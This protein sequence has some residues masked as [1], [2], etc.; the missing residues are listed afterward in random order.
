MNLLE[1]FLKY[2]SIHTTSN[3]NTGLVPSTPQQMEFAKILAEELKDMGMQDVS[4][5]KKGYLM[6]TLPSNIDKDVPTVG[7]PFLPCRICLLYRNCTVTTI[8]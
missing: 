4:L 8:D 7:L 5:D 6:A 2:V 1:R 3:E